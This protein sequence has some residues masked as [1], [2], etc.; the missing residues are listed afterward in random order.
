MYNYV[1]GRC[2]DLTGESYSSDP[3]CQDG[4]ANALT[5][6]TGRRKLSRQVLREDSC[7]RP[8]KAITVL[9]VLVAL[10]LVLAVSCDALF[11]TVRFSG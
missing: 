10:T 3:V 1:R 5:I 11:G 6:S 9:L 7:M 8:G 2:P 4:P